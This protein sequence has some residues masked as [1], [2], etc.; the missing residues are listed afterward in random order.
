[1]YYSPSNISIISGCGGCGGAG[2]RGGRGCCGRGCGDDDSGGG[3]GGAELALEA[4]D[5]VAIAFT[6]SDLMHFRLRYL[7][8]LDCIFR[9]SLEIIPLPLLPL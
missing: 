9:N 4:T 6:P 2:V 7:N 8:S 1:M 3:G 5:A